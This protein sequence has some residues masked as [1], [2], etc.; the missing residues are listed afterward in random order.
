[1]KKIF[2][3]LI[4]S[5]ILI[6]VFVSALSLDYTY[7]KLNQ[8]TITK[9][10][11]L[12]QV[13]KYIVSWVIL[14]VAVVVFFSLI[15]AGVKYLT[16][17]GNP[18]KMTEARGNITNAIIGLVIILI[19]YLILVT[20]NPQLIIL[21]IKTTPVGSATAL[22]SRQGTQA[23]NQSQQ[24]AAQFVNNATPKQRIYLN[25][26]IKDLRQ[27]AGDL[28]YLKDANDSIVQQGGIN[29]ATFENFE[30]DSL[31]FL[32]QSTKDL[33]KRIIAYSEPNFKGL[34]QIIDGESVGLDRI[35]SFDPFTSEQKIKGVKDEVVHPPLSIRIQG[36]GPG[37]YV[38]SHEKG[39][40]RYLTESV[41]DLK[42]LDKF[43]NKTTRVEIRNTASS[44]Y[45]AI[46]FKDP[47]F[48]KEL[49]IFFE[50]K[51]REIP[52]AAGDK[53]ELS[54]TDIGNTAPNTMINVKENGEKRGQPILDIFGK[55]N[56]VSS[57]YMGE[58]SDDPTVCEEV[59]ICNKTDLRGECIVYNLAGENMEIEEYVWLN[60]QKLPI[61]IPKNIPKKLTV[62]K[63][64]KDSV[65]EE[66]PKEA[67]FEDD[68]RSISI[69]GKCLVVLFDHK[70]NN[71]NWD[72]SG[73]GNNSQIFLTEGSDELEIKNL[74]GTPIHKCDDI[75][76]FR[77]GES[78]PCA[79]AIAIYPLK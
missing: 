12:G 38:Y 77:V 76:R 58:L 41:F 53:Y 27:V 17:T 70:I 40:E 47:D 36:V 21:E 23:L 71:G 63:L 37:V 59:R 24:S 11:S 62:R 54:S 45:I 7:P 19:S 72:S 35:Y 6:P 78:S 34:T 46:L 25:Y 9:D 57:V 10:S 20:I 66:N 31:I 79:S 68:I 15:R 61:Y 67:K 14:I 43:D 22:L 64:K 52:N 30:L 26:E 65:A 42:D 3:I 49:R 1:M 4:I 16:S 60:E 48:E 29:M 28:V 51:N 75:F 33:Q 44:D 2:K 69:K 55:A 39:Q 32:G 74:A 13:V 8:L 5:L 18:N 73:P 50:A 56:S